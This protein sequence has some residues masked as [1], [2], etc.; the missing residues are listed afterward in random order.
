MAGELYLNTLAHFKQVESEDSDGRMDS[1]EGVA[2]WWQPH[3][4][5]MK[6][7]VPG[8]GDIEITKADLAGPVSMA[9]DVHNNLHLLCLYAL[10]TTGFECV[11]GKI[12]Y[13]PEQADELQRQLQI[14]E[15][16][17]KFGTFAVITPAVSFLAQL[18]GALNNQR[19]K[20]RWKLVEYYNDATFHGGLP[21]N[22]IPFR[23]QKRFSYQREFRL[24]VYPRTE[25]EA[26][27]SNP[28]TI[29]IG[30][31]T[32]VCA[33]VEAAR[34]LT[35]FELKTELASPPA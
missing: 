5:V 22:E 1:T 15:R 25:E 28:I 33:K 17:R 9:F 3:D 35:F 19:Y 6:L 14:D 21:P 7:S 4:I 20:A 8:I 34:L 29:P 16:C 27:N 13:A 10:H 12:Y 30:D 18:C 31:L 2:M 11:D 24:C 32:H 26:A 23:K